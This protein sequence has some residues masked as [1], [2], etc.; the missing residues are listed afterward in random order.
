MYGDRFAETFLTAT[1]PTGLR[2]NFAPIGCAI[3]WAPF[4]AVADVAAR[5]AALFG[6]SVAVDGFSRPYLVAVTYGSAVHGMLA[7]ILSIVVSRQLFG[8]GHL[9]GVVT[10]LGTPL[11][12][13]MYVA[14]G[15]SHA[16]SAFAVSAFI[17]L[18]LEVRGRWSMRGLVG[19]GALA[20]LMGMVREQDLLVAIGPAV[21]FLV[22]MAK[23]LRGSGY[24]ALEL[25][26]VA[27]NAAA[28]VGVFA[29]V[30]SPQAV[31]YLLLNGRL[32]PA[33]DVTRKM[34]WTAPYAVQVLFS[35]QHGLFLWTPLAAVC[36]CGLVW[37]AAGRV[38]RGNPDAR[39]IS[40]LLLLVFVAQV[41]VSGSVTSWSTA[42]TFGHRR[43]VGLT[44]VL[45][46]GLAALLSATRTRSSRYVAWG[47]VVMS[48]WW[49]FGLM[50]QF[51]AGLM[52]RQRLELARN[53]YATFV[54]VPRLMSQLVYRY[55]FD[56]DSFYQSRS[57]EA[58]A[59]GT[60]S[61]VDG[62]NR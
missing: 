49:N 33:E 51:G 59:L 45:S 21:D 28:G 10:W 41:Y 13:Y 12:F 20:A 11:L 60:A 25:Q 46:V 4:Y 19:L 54:T 18:W 44:L 15:M 34:I 55:V 38:A 48:V 30:Y 61:R 32:G 16:C 1:T 35:P 62:S 56:R 29:V 3:L 47:V 58:Q 39:W 37:A 17:T 42:G 9:V 50:A 5:T 36:L 26:R 14:P 53:A 6:S 31:S 8:H 2:S 23:R 27:L 22:A 7:V 57:A 52:N 40:L 43:F 24:G